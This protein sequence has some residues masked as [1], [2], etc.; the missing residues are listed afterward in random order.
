MTEHTTE[1]DDTRTGGIEPQS[2]KTTDASSPTSEEITRADRE[3]LR[4]NPTLRPTV[5]LLVLVG[6][7]GGGIVWFLLRNPE[8]VFGDETFTELVTAAVAVLTVLIIIRLII[9]L[10]VLRRTQYIITD[11]MLKRETNLILYYWARKVPIEQLR[12]FEYSQNAIQMIL[13]YGSIRL[14]T[15]GTNQSIGF[16]VFDDIPNPDVAEQIL[17]RIIRDDNSP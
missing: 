10:I 16:V 14:L 13:S 12:G 3:L 15:A 4:T 5:I 9:R 11:D 8:L 7:I 17:N 1:E 2:Q 6:L